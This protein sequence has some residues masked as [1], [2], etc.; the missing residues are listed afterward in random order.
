MIN[1][2]LFYT[3]PP[4]KDPGDFPVKISIEPETGFS[5]IS[6]NEKTLKFAPKYSFQVG[7]NQ[8][9]IVLTN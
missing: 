7:T 4:Y 5:F 3:L 2:E 8:I 9:S 6:L 1:T